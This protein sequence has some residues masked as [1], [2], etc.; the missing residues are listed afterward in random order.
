MG[1]LPTDMRAQRESGDPIEDGCDNASEDDFQG[2][3]HR[4]ASVAVGSGGRKERVRDRAV[5]HEL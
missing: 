2:F 4:D 3:D 1:F 5:W